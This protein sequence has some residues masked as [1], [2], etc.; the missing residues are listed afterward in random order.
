VGSSYS[1]DGYPE[2]SLPTAPE[3]SLSYLSTHD[4][5]NDVSVPS[6]H[7]SGTGLYSPEDICAMI[8]HPAP[9][10]NINFPLSPVSMG[11]LCSPP[12]FA[13]L[14]AAMVDMRRSS[15][16]FQDDFA[17]ESTH[18]FDPESCDSLYSIPYVDESHHERSDPLHGLD[19]VSR[20]QGN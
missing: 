6:G 8:E 15:Y 3:S 9:N 12:T 1:V 17:Q 19:C 13:S 14:P 2:Y 16:G 5:D 7:W 4:I 10:A 20:V 18:V 11:S